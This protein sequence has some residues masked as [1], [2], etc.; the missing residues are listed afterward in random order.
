MK[1]LNVNDSK[2]IFVKRV[3]GSEDVCPSQYEEVSAEIL[4]KCGE[5]ASCILVF[6]QR[7]TK[8]IGIMLLDS[9]VAEGFV[10]SSHGQDLEDVGKS[11]FNELINRGLIQPMENYYGEVTGC[12]VH[13]MMLDLILSRCKEDNFTNVAYS[14]ED[15]MSMA[16]RSDQADLTAISQ[17]PQL[18]YLRFLGDCCKVEL[19]SSICGLVQLETLETACSAVIST[20]SDIGSLRCLSHLRLPSVGLPCP[21]GYPTSKSLRTLD[22]RPPRD[23]DIKSLGELTNLRELRLYFAPKETS[24]I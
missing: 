18:R 21:T 8:S 2:K 13:D 11:Y 15:Y 1:P 4:K 17:L 5:H 7:T 16:R 22:I 14:C 6:T 20:P 19:P 24:N 23:M 9:G 3:S 12:R 10:R